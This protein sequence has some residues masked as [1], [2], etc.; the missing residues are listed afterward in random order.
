V[1]GEGLVGAHIVL[2]DDDRAMNV[3]GQAGGG[4][5]TRRFDINSSRSVA[6]S[7]LLLFIPWRSY[8]AVKPDLEIE[9]ETDVCFLPREN[10][11]TYQD[12]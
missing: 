9:L 11:G 8:S 7:R 2:A 1:I 4:F 12:R 3:S 5:N 10:P 6:R